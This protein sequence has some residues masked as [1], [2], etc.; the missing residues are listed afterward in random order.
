ML[1]NSRQLQ[2]LMFLFAVAGLFAVTADFACLEDVCA[3]TQSAAYTSMGAIMKDRVLTLNEALERAGTR[4]SQEQQDT[5]AREGQLFGV[6]KL[7]RPVKHPNGAVEV[8]AGW[9]PE[10]PEGH[11]WRKKLGPGDDAFYSYVE[12]R[13]FKAKLF[14]PQNPEHAKAAEAYLTK[15]NSEAPQFV[16]WTY[17]VRTECEKKKLDA[18][19]VG[20]SNDASEEEDE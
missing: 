15:A 12:E 18:R 8:P 7:T 10:I 6:V 2:R 17:S 4:L 19:G 3:E 1:K 16:G 20:V 13:I 11:P 5:L 9:L 14:D